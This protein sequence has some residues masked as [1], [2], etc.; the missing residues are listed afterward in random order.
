M[1]VTAANFFEQPTPQETAEGQ[2]PRDFSGRPL[3][4]CPPGMNDEYRR[5]KDGLVPY[6]RASSFG[7][8]LEDD[9]NLVLW[10]K[11]QVLMGGARGGAAMMQRVLQVGDPEDVRYTSPDQFKGRKAALNRIVE[12]AEE[13]AG[14]NYKAKVGTAIHGA[15]ELADLGEDLSGLH[16]ILRDRAEAYVRFCRTN[17]IR[18]TSVEQFGVQDDLRVAGTWDRTGW[19]RRKHKIVDV[20]TNSTMDFAGITYAV[21]LAAYSRMCAY[22]PQAGTRTPH[23]IM[24]LEEGIIIHIDRREG[25]PVT[26][27]RVNLTTGWRWAALVDLVKTAQREGTRSIAPVGVEDPTSFAIANCA[28]LEQLNLV[29]QM[30]AGASRWTDEHRALAATVA[31]EIRGAA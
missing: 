28:T 19:W 25:G 2:V 1:T 12:E 9:Y 11:R 10:Q 27:H 15:T 21:Q 5:K 18:V 22:D 4:I 23:E 20:K 13:L 29:W 31:S 3:I 6:H 30:T 26:L 8:Q 14:S 17:A 24:D 7:H 16:P